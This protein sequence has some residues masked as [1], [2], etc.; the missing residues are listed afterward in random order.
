RRW[1]RVKDDVSRDGSNVC[2]TALG[3]TNEASHGVTKR[4]K[5]EDSDGLFTYLFL[6]C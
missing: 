1:R 2:V 5:P 4:A 6:V 3:K